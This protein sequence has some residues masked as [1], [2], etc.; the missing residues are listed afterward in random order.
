M[1]THQFNRVAKSVGVSC[2]LHDLRH[3]SATQMIANGVDLRTVAGRLGRSGG[4]AITLKVYS[5]WTLPADQHA[6][7]VLAEQLRRP[8]GDR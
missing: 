5:H 1:V 2:R 4:G 3:Y 6:A 8:S 7:E